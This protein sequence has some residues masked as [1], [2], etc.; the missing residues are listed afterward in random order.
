MTDNLPVRV[1]NAV[2]AKY[3][4]VVPYLEGRAALIYCE[5]KAVERDPDEPGREQKDTLEKKIQRLILKRFRRQLAQ[6]KEQLEQNY[7]AINTSGVFIGDE[8]EESAELIK[9]IYAELLS[10]VEL[11]SADIGIYLADGS[12]NTR[13]LQIARTY[14]TD[15]LAQLDE[16]SQNA[17]RD[18]VETFV[19]QPGTTV[20]D[21]VDMLSST[22]GDTRALRI[23][24]TETTRV[25][26]QANELFGQELQVQYP[27]MTVTK[28][29]FT[30]VDD[31]VCP[32]CAPLHNKEVGLNE[33]FDGIDKPPAHPNCRCFINV[34]VKA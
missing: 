24:V 3:P 27:D 34:T 30:N 18:A 2:V 11:S 6:I 19:R 20:G 13:A 17:V 25:Y 22:F 9:L 7:K 1:I 12:I 16:A 23:A 21:M 10:G 5:H 33:T 32:I 14:V 4:A 31:R 29:W 26:A 15:W 8:G 28:R